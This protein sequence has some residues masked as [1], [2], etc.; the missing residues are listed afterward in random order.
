MITR[1]AVGVVAALALAGCTSGNPQAGQAIAVGEPGKPAVITTTPADGAVDVSPVEAIS[2]AV[3][4]GEL[5]KVALTN[6]A[7]KQVKGVLDGATWTASEPLGYGKTYTWSGAVRGDDGERVELTGD[8]TT[9]TPSSTVHASLNVA[10]DRTYGVA[11]P[12]KVTFDPPVT[13]RAAAER[14]LTVETSVPTE[15]SWA[16]LNGGAAAHWRPKAY[17]KPNTQVTVTAKVYGVDL[18][19][20]AYGDE[21]V[22]AEFTIGRSQIVKADTKTHRMVVIRD[23]KKVHDFP[24]SY[25]LESDRRRV[26]RSGTHVVM[27]K[28]RVK[29]MT[30]PTFGYSDVEVPFA[31]RIHNNGE[32][33]HGYADSM[34]A[35]GKENVSHGCINLSPANAEIYFNSVLTGDPVE[36]VSDVPLGE[37]DADYGDYYDW[38]I[39]WS[40]WQKKSALVG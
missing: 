24:A 7:G 14:R 35:Q 5:E 25:G 10:D 8:F 39:P 20:G 36:V 9:A 32:F 34:W 22:S 40:E 16:W 6:P 17:W 1:W 29:A 11:M 21:D 15:G 28:Y 23:G 12:I 27:E 13:D 31:V 2:V 37:F 26:T 33:I 19:D 4:N 38:A 30:N 3:A 18:G